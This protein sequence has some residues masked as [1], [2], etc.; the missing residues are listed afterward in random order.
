[1]VAAVTLAGIA[2]DKAK[3]L[4]P[5]A[6]T[7]ML[8]RIPK[9]HTSFIDKR[10]TSSQR[11]CATGRHSNAALSSAASIVHNGQKLRD[12]GKLDEALAAFQKA[13]S[14]I[15]LLSSPSRNATAR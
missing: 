12:D 15:L 13:M 11:I 2:A 9:R 3:D 4:S 5:K 10:T 14:M 1:L 6:R 8:A 7:R